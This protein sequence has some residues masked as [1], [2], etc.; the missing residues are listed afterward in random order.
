[1]RGEVCI[2]TASFLS[3]AALMM[4]IFVHIG[5]IN[6]AKVPRGISMV[7]VNMSGYGDGLAVA[8][9]DPIFGLYAANDTI[10]LERHLGLRDE[11]RFGLYGWCASVSGTGLCSNVS[12]GNRF[13]PFTVILADMPSNYSSI[14]TSLLTRGTFIDSDYLGSFTN[15]AYYLILIGTIATA[16]TFFTG[17]LKHTLLFLLSTAFALISV[18][19]LLIGAAIWTVIIKKGQD[20][21]GFVVGQASNPASVGITVETGN[22]LILL[23]AAW[24]SVLVSTLPYMIRQPDSAA[25]LLAVATGV[26]ALPKVTRNGR[27]LYNEDGSRFFVK[28]IAYQEQGV[29]STDPNNPFSEPSTFI[30]PLTDA[31]ACNRDIPFLKQ[32]T[33]NA[34]RIYSVNSSLNHDDCMAAFSAAG[35]YMIIDLALPGEG[36]IDRLQPEW[37]TDLLNQYINTIN[38]FNKY[39]NVLAYNIGNE[40]ITDPGEGTGAAPF[41]KAAARDT[42]AYLDSIKSSALVGYAA[43]DGADNWVLPLAEY[44]ACDPSNGNSGSTSIDLFGLNNYEFCGDDSPSVYNGK[45]GDFAGYNVPAY[46]SEFGCV[47]NPPRLWTEVETIFSQPMS[48]VWSGGL[49]FSY[50]PATSGGGSFGMVTIDGS[51]VT[52]SDDF[53]RLVS[54]YGKVSFPTVPSQ[55]DAGATQYP[56]C[57]A[58]NDAWMASITIPPTPNDASCSCLDS[59]LSCLFTPQTSNVSAIVGSLLDF[60]CSQL[61]QNG[62]NC[63]DI[64]GNG[65]LGTYGRVAFCDP[66]TKLSF[67]MS[68]FYEITNRVATSCDFSGNATVN[69]KAPSSIQDANAAASSCLASPSAVFTPSAPTTT[70]GGSKATDSGSSPGKSGAASLL[71]A[72]STAIVGVAVAFAFSVLGSALVIA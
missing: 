7:K 16:L 28:G 11:Y 10:P 71:G 42:R 48:N 6:T 34:V 69:S 44:L 51:T 15:G 66:S 52:T 45:N 57:P 9:G 63:N 55:S 38:V 24:A 21:N 17:L 41:I 30:D 56:S 19:T 62:G 68:E 67:V 37:T 59:V 29:L 22:A 14:T 4:L 49:A 72:Q 20:I 18:V 64:S 23:W 65:T 12:A 26:H 31:S 70:T 46:F 3:F 27:Y 47:S 36:S 33:V 43:I 1:M 8:L 54:Q 39:D 2:G 35:I 25:P 50:F 60:T 32:L 53:T 40:I 61:G 5:Q 13:E 58:T